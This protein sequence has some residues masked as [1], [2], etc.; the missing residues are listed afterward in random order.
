M[1]GVKFGGTPEGTIP[2]QASIKEGVETRWHPPKQK[3]T[4]KV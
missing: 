4:V 2:S 1:N 3:C